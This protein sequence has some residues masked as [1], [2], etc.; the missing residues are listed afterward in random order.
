MKTINEPELEK[1]EED[2]EEDLEEESISDFLEEQEEIKYTKED[3]EQCVRNPHQYIMEWAEENVIHVGK[4]FFKV[5]ALQPCSLLLP[6]IAFRST[7]IRS[8]FN[9]MFIAPP[10]SGKST[11]C[12]KYEEIVF[13]PYSVRSFSSAELT[14]D[15]SK[16]DFFTVIIEDFSQMCEDYDTIKVLEGA[17]GD[18]KILNKRTKREQINKKTNGVGLICGTWHDLK[19]YLGSLKSGMFSRSFL[20]LLDLTKEQQRDIGRYINEGV[21]N[22]KFSAQSMIKEKVIKDYYKNIQY[23]MMGKHKEIKKVTDFYLDD[24]LK[25]EIILTSWEKEIGLNKI[26][27]DD[28]SHEIDD[29]FTR[30]L[31]EGYRFVI[32]SALLNIFNRKCENGILYPNKEDFLLAKELMIENLRNKI[33]LIKSQ[34]YCNKNVKGDREVLKKILNSNIPRIN[35][36][37]IYHLSGGA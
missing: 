9:I 36:K 15:L 12:R 31:Q 11:I 2:L 19:K 22:K 5:L 27:S 16:K 14:T 21:G 3:F 30:E 24:L 6:N 23:I 29:F 26:K 25:K 32:S 10:S 7:S 33:N 4:K 18:E 35:K 20:F 34:W 1:V 17:L 13:N 37:I 8:S 28:D